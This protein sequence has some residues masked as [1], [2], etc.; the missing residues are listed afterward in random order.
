MCLYVCVCMSALRSNVKLYA[1]QWKKKQ[2]LQTVHMFGMLIYISFLFGLVL[3]FSLGEVVMKKVFK[4][5][6]SRPRLSNSC[7]RSS[8]HPVG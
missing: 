1:S 7:K 6:T 5:L 4:L 8:F 2:D 3:R